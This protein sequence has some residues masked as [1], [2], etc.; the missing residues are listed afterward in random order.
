M[1]GFTLIE[2]LAVIVILAIILLIAV[3]IINN[4]I[5]GVRKSAFEITGK[6]I[7][8]SAE[9]LYGKS[10]IE[11]NKTDLFFEYYNGV[12]IPNVEGM[13]IPMNGEVP[14]NGTVHI[15]TDGDIEI[16][17]HNG[18]YCV[19]KDFSSNEFI[20]SEIEVEDCY[21]PFFLPTISLIGGADEFVE[22]NQSY[23]DS[24]VIAR[25]V[26]GT[27]SDNFSYVIKKDD[28]IVQE[29]DANSLGIY[30]ITYTVFDGTKSKS[31]IRKVS[32]VDTIDPVISLATNDNLLISDVDGFDLLDGVSVSDNSLEDLSISV[33]GNIAKI[34]GSYNITYSATDSSGNTVSVL[35]IINVSDVT[36]PVLSLNGASSINVLKDSAYTELGATAIDDSEGD[37]TS[38][39]VITG[40]VNTAV[41]GTYYVT[42]TVK[43]SSNNE[44]SITRTVVVIPSTQVFDFTYTGN[45]QLFV[46]PY[47]GVYKLETW[48]AQGG[49]TSSFAGGKGGYATGRLNLTAG[50]NLYVYVGGQATS[51]AGGFNGGGAG[52]GGYDF[53]GVGGGGATDI[54][55]NTNSLTNRIIVAGGGGGGN[56]ATSSTGGY[57]GGPAGGD[58]G[59]QVSYC[60]SA[61]GGGGKDY[62]G[63]IGGT[64][65]SSCG[66]SGSGSAGL[67]GSGGV[68]G[69]GYNSGTFGS[70][71]GG[72]GGYYGGGGGG[73]GGNYGSAGGGGSAYTGTLTS[74]T[75]IPGNSA[76]PGPTGTNITGRVGNGFAKITFNP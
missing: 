68:G 45:Y 70:G 66:T 12:E 29:I 2:L 16:K 72:G 1:K 60:V 50:T 49:N 40:N 25:N 19:V 62:T 28:V 18:K 15:K 59:T 20:V 24:G 43:D 32:I 26:D 52:G 36:A 23:T 33:T 46:V 41:A 48:G 47:T 10:L 30:E 44:S 42:Y 57:G 22:I 55:I 17:I 6:E 3:P 56:H 75:S 14:Q 64:N 53:P 71:S 58:G 54:R 61:P 34:A 38:F 31:I 67:L 27:L 9:L 74:A 4:V 8:K 21:T 35:R 63:G 5:E 13:T 69:I 51:T 7:K 65:A 11:D 37:V 76:M 73:G 39:I